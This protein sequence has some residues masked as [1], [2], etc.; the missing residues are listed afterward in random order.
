M[1]SRLD[2]PSEEVVKRIIDDSLH[3]ERNGLRGKAYFDA[4][5]PKPDEA[6]VKKMVMGYGFYDRSIHM[7]AERVKKSGRM[8]VVVNDKPGLF[9]PGDCPESSTLLRV[10]QP[11]TLCGCL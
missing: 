7:A 10:V 4:R 6:K 9:Q 8:E 1:V 5:W 11:C 2:G 3:A